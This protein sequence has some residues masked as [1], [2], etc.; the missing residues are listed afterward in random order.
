MPL[1][2]HQK[3]IYPKM[4]TAVLLSIAKNRKGTNC[5]WRWDK[6]YSHIKEHNKQ[7]KWAY[8]YHTVWRNHT[9]NAEWKKPESRVWLFQYVCSKTIKTLLWHWK[10]R[11]HFPLDGGNEWLERGKGGASEMLLILCFLICVHQAV[12]YWCGQF[13]LCFL[14]SVNV[15]THRNSQR[16]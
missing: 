12:Y 4:F 1:Y 15:K 10:S 5:P 3:D 8:E 9:Y 6:R 13:Y 14:Y 16:V 11:K 7:W 2:V